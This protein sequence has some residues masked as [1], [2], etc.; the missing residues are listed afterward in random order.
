MQTVNKEKKLIYP[1]Q[2]L[3][4]DSETKLEN[5]INY[6]FRIFHPIPSN[7]LISINYKEFARC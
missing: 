3:S 6:K 5:L 4:Q 7:M 1:N 2:I